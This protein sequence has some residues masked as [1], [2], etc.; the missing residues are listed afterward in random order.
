MVFLP[1]ALLLALVAAI[2]Y[3]QD[4]ANERLIHVHEGSR[5]VDLQAEIISRELKSVQSDL[6]YLSQQAGL[7]DVL[8]GAA[9]RERLER[10]Y[11]SFCA[12]KGIYDQIR[13][14]NESGREVVRINYND[15]AP[16]VVPESELQAKATRY[17]FDKAMA[18]DQG[19]IYISPFDLNV[20][21]D[22][23]EMPLKPV[24]RFAAP[25]DDDRGGRRGIL[26]LNYLGAKLLGKLTEVSEGFSGSVLLLNGEGFYL[27]GR[28]PEDEW[29]F[30]LGND[31]GFGRFHPLAWRRITAEDRGQFIEA[32]GLFSF[33]TVAS[34][35]DA[36]GGLIVV[37]HVPEVTR[38]QASR[39]LLRKIL[40]V[41]AGVVPLLIV[42]VF[43]LS[44]SSALRRRHERRLEDS[45]A[46]LRTLSMELLAAQEKERRKISRDLHDDLGQLSTAVCLDLERAAQLDDPQKM[47]QRIG[48]ALSEARLL[49]ERIHGISSSLRPTILD[50]LGLKDA[51]QSY[52]ADYER[53]TGVTVEAGLRFERDSIPAAVSENIFR[54]LQEALTNVSKHAGASAV[55]VALHASNGRIEIRVRD[56]GVGFDPG[57][58]EGNGL[59]LLGMR[60]RAE[61]L[62]GTFEL[63][64]RAGAGTEVRVAIPLQTA[65]PT[66]SKDA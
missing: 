66:R 7:R 5:I 64:T 33:R 60:E 19:Q 44:Y 37:A 28:A 13:F 36:G 20:E 45:E 56:D 16:S 17:Y 6:L 4:L 24:I 15:G 12:H 31:R 58:V 47:K 3:R 62:G 61:L 46:R 53:K 51:V 59:G 49:L 38:H 25:V 52:L 35:S 48:Q 39:Q 43:Y 32:E 2:L 8:S 26:V 65:E 54:I 22:R 10:E 18:L 34:G 30:A 27:R 63:S 40:A 14:L 1:A 9:N 57:R 11:L 42:L 41:Y 21:H 55:R 50:D 29:G 23:L